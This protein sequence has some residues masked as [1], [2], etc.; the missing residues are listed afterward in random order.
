MYQSNTSN[1]LP[2]HLIFNTFLTNSVRN[3]YNQYHETTI[4]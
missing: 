1:N 3:M 2:I 4:T